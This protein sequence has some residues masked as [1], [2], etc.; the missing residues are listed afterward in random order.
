MNF[1]KPHKVFF[2]VVILHFAS[3]SFPKVFI[4][5]ITYLSKGSFINHVCRKP[6]SKPHPIFWTILAHCDIHSPLEFGTIS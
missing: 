2:N 5:S 6:I 4:F 1:C 3:N